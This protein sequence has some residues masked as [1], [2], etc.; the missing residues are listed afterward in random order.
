MMRISKQAEY[1][2]AG[3]IQ[4]AKEAPK[5][6]TVA[7][8]ATA[9]GCPVP[10]LAKIFQQ[11]TKTNILKSYPGHNGGFVLGRPASDIT[12]LEVVEAIEGRIDMF[13]AELHALGDVWSKAQ[14]VLTTSLGKSKLSDCF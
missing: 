9:S 8:I 2:L 1:A 6:L 5:K 14:E 11:L 3:A 7:Q 10:Y 4:L 13:S 12:V